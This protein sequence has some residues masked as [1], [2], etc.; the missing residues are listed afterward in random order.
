MPT[1]QRYGSGGVLNSG[2]P[3]CGAGFQ[4]ARSPFRERLRPFLGRGEPRPR[5]RS[6]LSASLREA[7][8]LCPEFIPVAFNN[9]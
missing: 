2:D 3:T 8:P 4:P 9:I 7:R 6:A 1:D 5:P